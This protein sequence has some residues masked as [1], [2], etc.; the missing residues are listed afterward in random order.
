MI[1]FYASRRRPVLARRRTRT[2]WAEILR[3]RSLD[4]VAPPCSDDFCFDILFDDFLGKIGIWTAILE[5]HAELHSLGSGRDGRVEPGHVSIARHDDLKIR[6]KDAVPVSE[7]RLQFERA[8]RL[9]LHHRNFWFL[10]RH[11]GGRD[12]RRRRWRARSP[13]PARAASTR[14][15]DNNN[16]GR[17]PVLIGAA[18]AVAVAVAVVRRQSSVELAMF[19]P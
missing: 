12:K 9:V 1:F 13:P 4:E 3:V 2:Y 18:V 14:L 8:R 19:F 15:M 16:S 11:E 17:G 5:A 7:E 6:R 10:R